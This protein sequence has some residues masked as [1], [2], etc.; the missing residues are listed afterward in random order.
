[1]GHSGAGAPLKIPTMRI[2]FYGGFGEKGRT[3]LGIESDGYRLLLDA[4]VKTSARGGDDYYP[5]I[6]AERLKKTD[7]MIVTH[8]HEDHLAAVG[9]CID[10]GFSG[11]IFM[12][13]ETRG[14]AESCLQAYATPAHL[15]LFRRA[16]VERLGLGSDALRLGPLRIS[17]GRSG[18]IAGGVWCCVDDGR[19][20]LT[21]CSD[22]VPASTIFAVDPLPR[23]DAIA[24]DASYGDDDVTLGERAAQVSAWIKAQSIGC[25]LPTTL[26]GRSLE[27]FAVIP[28][29]VALAPDMREALAM[30]I[31]G[32]AW[33]VERKADTL[34]E[35]LDATEDWREDSPLPAAA[36]L[37]HDAM[38]LAG[39]STKILD[40]ARAQSHATLFTGHLPTGSPGERMVNE[41]RAKWIRFP[42]HPTLSE[43]RR[44][45]D[46]S[47]AALAFG[48]SCEPATLARLAPHIPTL[49]SDV[50][51]GAHIDI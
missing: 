34:S 29:R 27:L 7:A 21:Y 32:Q 15:D 10:R 19:V 36:L 31:E 47:G 12:T 49:R 33:L 18:H 50:S 35:R 1:M 42:T 43:N 24:I 51:T 22:I 4:G 23:C 11:Q 25:V 16:R 17:T 8:A 45:V 38:G 46:A 2:D 14:E 37:C 41:G 5:A 13:D 40:M 9:W 28:G 26:Y 6:S 3:C 44:M 30:Q 39:P 20:K 48:H